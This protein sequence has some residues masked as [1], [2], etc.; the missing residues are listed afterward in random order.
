MEYVVQFG[1]FDDG[2]PLYNHSQTTGDPSSQM[3][4]SQP[5]NKG[6]CI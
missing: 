2:V 4:A 1:L 6:Q 5:H 3:T